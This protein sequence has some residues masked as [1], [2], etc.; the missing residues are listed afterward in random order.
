[1]CLFNLD[2]RNIQKIGDLRIKKNKKLG[3]GA[4]GV[5]FKGV[6]KFRPCAVKV[7]HQLATE[8]Q[9]DL[10]ATGDGQEETKKAFKIECAFLKSFDH[11]NV[12]QHLS[13]TKHPSSG[14][15]ILV[16]ELMDYSLRSYLSNETPTAQV[17][18]SICK[19]IASA[20]AYIHGRS[21]VHRDLCGDNVLLNRV[22]PVAKISDFGMSR[23]I[24]CSAMS[25]TLTALGHRMGY[26]PPEAPLIESSRYDSSL[27]V[28]SFGVI[29]TQIVHTLETVKSPKDRNYYVAQIDHSH[30]LKP[31][32]LRCLNKS[33]DKRPLASD[34]ED[35]LKRIINS[36]C[37]QLSLGMPH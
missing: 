4:F 34:L 16:T 28:F 15:A 23:I 30:R 5:V 12:V 17:E 7:L 27:D 2:S 35:E 14:Q 33:K 6:Y 3:S 1:M 18:T 36:V 10:P 32:I 11:P 8:I 37:V 25:S 9:T 19:D 26:L 22:G 13:T 31:W 24:D 20:L 21:I 29:M